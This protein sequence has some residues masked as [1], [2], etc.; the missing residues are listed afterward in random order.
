MNIPSFLPLHLMLTLPSKS[1]PANPLANVERKTEL[2]YIDG[3]PSNPCP[4]VPS[5]ASRARSANGRCAYGRSRDAGVGSKSPASS[6]SAERGRRV[7]NAACRNALPV[8]REVRL[9]ERGIADSRASASGAR[10]TIYAPRGSAASIVHFRVHGCGRVVYVHERRGNVIGRTEERSC[11]HAPL[12]ER[13]NS[14]RLAIRA[15]S[16]GYKS[17][18]TA[19]RRGLS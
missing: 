19:A 18:R 2:A 10:V 8:R 6:R 13:T 11:V 9:R 15:G 3:Q 14:G 5:L 17:G 7:R 16:C 4:F 1:D 12:G